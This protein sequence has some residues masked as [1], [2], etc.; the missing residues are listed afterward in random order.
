MPLEKKS[1]DT[2]DETMTPNDKQSA[3]VVTLGDKQFYK[4]TIQPGWRWTTD[5]KPIVQTD[6]C[7]MD[8]LM[9]VLSGKVGVKMDDGEELEYG[10]G[11]VVAIPP[12]HDGWTIGDEPAVWIELPH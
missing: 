2:P 8:H 1:F 10:A 12:G 11:D 3:A 6:T 5:M 7:Q 4:I 9:Y